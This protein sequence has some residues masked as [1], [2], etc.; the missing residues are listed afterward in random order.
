MLISSEFLSLLIYNVILQVVDKFWGLR[1][2]V[3]T[4]SDDGQLQHMQPLDRA[5]ALLSESEG[6]WTY[7]GCNR[8]AEEALRQELKDVQ[9]LAEENGL[10]AKE[11]QSRA[12]E[13]DAQLVLPYSSHVNHQIR[14]SCIRI[15]DSVDVSVVM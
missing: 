1:E 10:A 15:W 7:G 13:L 4:V 8:E 12:N 9:T 2:N 6:Q 14:S 5:T 11:E 3:L